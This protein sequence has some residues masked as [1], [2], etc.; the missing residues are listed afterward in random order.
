MEHGIIAW[1][2]I[3]AIAGWLAGVLVKGGGFGLIVDIIVGIVGAFIGGWLAGVLHIS[4]GG[5]WIGSIITAVIG[6]VILL[7]LVRLVRRGA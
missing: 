2:I 7:F 4:L 1:L 3:G 5:G 6:A